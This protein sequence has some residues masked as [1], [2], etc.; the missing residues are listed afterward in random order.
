M[1]IT[2]VYRLFSDNL[3]CLKL[4]HW[5]LR[6]CENLRFFSNGGAG[7]GQVNTNCT[8]LY[9]VNVDVESLYEKET[10]LIDTDDQRGG[11]T[12][13]VCTIVHMLCI[14]VYICIYMLCISVYICI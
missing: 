12:V 3:N 1:F 13:L 4:K 10:W 8:S 6:L 2:F 11:T 9:F 14:S 5:S 7:G